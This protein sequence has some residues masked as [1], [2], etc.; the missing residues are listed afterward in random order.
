MKVLF[1]FVFFSCVFS[2]V[3][4]LL[5][6]FVAAVANCGVI[7]CVCFYVFLVGVLFCLS[8]FDLP[9]FVD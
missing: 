4:L 1:G 8:G 2:F 3:V 7:F 9:M 5:S 6:S